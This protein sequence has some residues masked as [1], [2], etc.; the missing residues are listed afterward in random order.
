MPHDARCPVTVCA[1]GWTCE[2]CGSQP[3]VN[4]RYILSAQVGDHTGFEYVTFFDA[5]AQTLLGRSASAC[6]RNTSALAAMHGGLGT[7]TF[8]PLA[9]RVVFVPTADELYA[10]VAANGGTAPAAFAAVLA[11][12]SYKE[13][14]IT[15]KAKLAEV[16]RCAVCLGL[17][18]SS[19][20]GSRR[21]LCRVDV[22]VWRCCRSKA[23]CAPR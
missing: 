11:S 21:L 2:K 17:V 13:V 9:A 8:A 3:S 1:G 4:H 22:V 5:E 7:F 12:V 19:A 20:V 6:K 23:R 18:A 10:M 16:R 15:N 14:L